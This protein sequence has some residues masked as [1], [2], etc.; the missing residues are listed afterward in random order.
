MITQLCPID[1]ENVTWLHER[2]CIHGIGHGLVKLYYFNTTA[3]VD[4]CYEFIH[5]WAEPMLKRGIYGEHR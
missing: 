5:L 3:A 2:D 1:Q 4:R